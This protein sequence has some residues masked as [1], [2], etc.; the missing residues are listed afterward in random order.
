VDQLKEGGRII[1]P[2]GPTYNQ[3]LVLLRKRGGKLERHAV[4][5]V[6]FVPMTGQP[7]GNPKT[8]GRNPKEG[9]GPKS[10]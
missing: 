8:E 10:E 9:R 4:L 1:I 3:E 2:I 7:N 5:P 6:S